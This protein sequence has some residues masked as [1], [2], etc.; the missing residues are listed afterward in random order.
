M[1][2]QVT[3]QHILDILGHLVD[4]MQ[5]FES[6]LA[7]EILREMCKGGVCLLQLMRYYIIYVFFLFNAVFTELKIDLDKPVVAGCNTATSASTLA[8]I[9]KMMG[10]P[11]LP[12]YPVSQ[13]I[14]HYMH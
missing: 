12:L 4:S 7:E 6:R 3:I 11:D 2:L 1:P 5:I 9:V 10:K 14:V 8:L 13:H